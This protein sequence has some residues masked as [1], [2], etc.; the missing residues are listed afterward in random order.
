MRHQAGRR[1]R[2][3][4]GPW[5]R[6]VRR[7]R[8]RNGCRELYDPGRSVRWQRYAP[9]PLASQPGRQTRRPAKAFAVARPSP[10]AA[11]VTSATFPS[12]EMFTGTSCDLLSQPSTPLTL[13]PCGVGL[14]IAIT[15]DGDLR[16]G[17][18]D[19]PQLVPRQ[20][21]RR[22]SDVLLQPVE[23]GSAG[24]RND[25]WLLRQEPCQ[26][27]LRRCG[28][29]LRPDR[30][31]QVNHRPVC[32]ASSG[33]KARQ[34]CAIVVAAERGRLVDLAGEK[35]S[36]ERAKGDEAYPEFLARRQHIC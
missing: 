15:D 22:R 30:F 2:P 5:L 14:G 31:Q 12:N 13:R 33:R 4:V 8:R 10:D 1:P 19:P 32:L 36:S 35:A 20:Y 25:P 7:R 26:R 3:S 23:F 27:D 28:A 21:D 16:G 34:A 17:V 11:P 18:L 6:P 29:L 24:D 9:R